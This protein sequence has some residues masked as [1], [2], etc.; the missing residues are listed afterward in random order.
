LFKIG[1]SPQGFDTRNDIKIDTDYNM[2]YINNMA[3]RKISK[4]EEYVLRIG[5][6]GRIVIPATIRKTL[7]LKPGEV[8]VGRVENNK[9]VLSKRD[10]MKEL[11]AMFKNAKF[12]TKDFIAERKEEAKKEAKKLRLEED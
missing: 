9:V 5:P 11:R 8:V 6:Q 7:G 1:R 3:R 4:A 10:P 2:P 12:S